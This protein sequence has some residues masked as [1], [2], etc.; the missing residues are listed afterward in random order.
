MNSQELSGSGPSY[1]DCTGS[2]R[3][4]FGEM[5]QLEYV[6]K[7]VK[8]MTAA[9]VARTRLPITPSILLQLRQICQAHPCRQDASMLWAAACMCLFGFLRAGEVVVPSASDYDPAV[10]LS[11][12]DVRA[13]N[14]ASPQY[15]EILIKASKTDPFRRG[16]SIYL[17]RGS[18]DLCPVAA[19]L[20]YMVQRGSAP[21]PFFRFVNGNYLTRERFVT[22]I[23]TALATAGINPSHYAGHSFR[24]GATT[25]AVR[26]GVQDSFIKTLGRWE[27]SAY[28]VYT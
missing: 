9:K 10:H 20:N 8:K 7:G 19:V 15:R 12:G 3:S 22:A 21:G 23:R 17:G 16:V 27:S 28:T 14:T 26:Q 13:E 6:S 11:H 2:G 25:T 24:I 1:S 5:P 4:P 18:C